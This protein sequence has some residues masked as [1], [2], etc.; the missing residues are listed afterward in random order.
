MTGHLNPIVRF[1]GV[2]LRESLINNNTDKRLFRSRCRRFRPSLPG[3]GERE[4][5]T[6]RG[7]GGRVEV[8]VESDEKNIRSDGINLSY[9]CSKNKHGSVLLM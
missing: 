9:M 3:K 2:V 1:G 4:V 5:E 8:C 7:V 6:K